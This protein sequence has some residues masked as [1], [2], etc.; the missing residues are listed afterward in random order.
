MIRT[1]KNTSHPGKFWMTAHSWGSWPLIWG[2]EESIMGDVPTLRPWRMRREPG[3]MWGFGG[4]KDRG[5]HVHEAWGQETETVNSSL[6]QD[7]G[8]SDMGHKLVHEDICMWGS[9]DVIF[10]ARELH[11]WIFITVVIS[12]II[13]WNIWENKV[14]FLFWK[15]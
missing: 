1:V 15:I 3:N 7:F 5:S 2:D 9:L 12:M 10:G 8:L 11:W 14:I 4:K 6:W 13:I